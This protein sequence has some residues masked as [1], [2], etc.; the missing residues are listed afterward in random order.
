MLSTAPMPPVSSQTKHD[1]AAAVLA[2]ALPLSCA[3]AQ[4]A[5]PVVTSVITGDHLPPELVRC[6]EKVVH[7]FTSSS[8]SAPG[9]Q[10]TVPI[11]FELQR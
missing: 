11:V 3:A 1:L 2:C 7:D 8:P 4:P 10:I 5:P 6:L 9:S